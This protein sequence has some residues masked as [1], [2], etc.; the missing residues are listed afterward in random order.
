M[1]MMASFSLLAIVLSL[2]LARL[3]ADGRGF[4]AP[5]PHGC[6]QSKAQKPPQQQGAARPPAEPKPAEP[7]PP[8]AA[9][10]QGIQRVAWLQGCWESVTPSRVV[11]EQW[12]TPRGGSMLGLGRTVKGDKLVDYEMVLLYEKGDALAYEAHPAGQ[13]S[14]TFLST[15]VTDTTVVF[16]NKEHDFPQRIGYKR[17][18]DDSLLAWIEG[19]EKERMRRIEFPYT[20][21]RCPQ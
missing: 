10:G 3:P 18:G 2:S 9:A 19:T 7:A 16:E 13:P 12:M 6:A 11:E 5:S 4:A 20:R 15:S 8:A 21:A 14:A 1:K 17:S